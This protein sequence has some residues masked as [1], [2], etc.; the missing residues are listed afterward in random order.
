MADRRSKEFMDGVHEFIEAAEKHKY[1][2]FVHCPCKF[3]KNEKDYSSSRIIHSHLF[4]SGFMPNYYVWTK[5]GGRGIV[6][7][8]NVEIIPFSMI[9]QW[10]S[11]KKIL[12]DTL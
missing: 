7:D 4:N 10:V 11:L 5:H 9:L 12:K 1:G 2:G 8:N 3:Y 6:L